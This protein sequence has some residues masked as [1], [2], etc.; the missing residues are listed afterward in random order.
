MLTTVIEGMDY[1]HDA[2]DI[3][4]LKTAL[5]WRPM[6]QIQVISHR[7]SDARWH[8]D[9]ALG[10]ARFARKLDGRIKVFAREVHYEQIAHPS[11]PIHHPEHGTYLER[12]VDAEWL[13]E[14]VKP[15][16]PLFRK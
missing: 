13:D 11:V 4:A 8:G 16:A 2:G 10:V 1:E 12:I 14:F 3:G 7:N 5:G 6:Q 15:D 9:V